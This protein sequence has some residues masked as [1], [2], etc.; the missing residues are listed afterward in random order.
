MSQTEPNSKMDEETIGV[1]ESVI[2]A[3][4]KH[5]VRPIDVRTSDNQQGN[6]FHTCPV[7]KRSLEREID[8][9]EREYGL[10]SGM[11]TDLPDRGDEE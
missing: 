9:L 2:C 7:C 6:G 8:L 11:E 5:E 10:K 3:N 4:C 1:E